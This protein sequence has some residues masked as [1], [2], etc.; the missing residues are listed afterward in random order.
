M[1]VSLSPYGNASS[2]PSP[3]NRMMDAFAAD[4]RPGCDINLGVG[5]VNE[6]TIP[7]ALIREALEHVLANP[8]RHKTPFN[9]A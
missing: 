2:T 9:S 6:R 8:S 4:F 7:V 1:D 5:Y 3:V